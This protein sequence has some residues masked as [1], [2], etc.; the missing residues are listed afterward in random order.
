MRETVY[1]VAFQAQ[2]G[3][4]NP[5]PVTLHADALTEQEM[6][7]MTK[8]FG[9]ESAFLMEPTR[10]DCQVKARYFVPLHEME[11]CIHATVASTVVLV[12]RGMFSVSP[13]VFE[14]SCGAVRADWRREKDGSISVGVFQFLPRFM[15]KNPSREEVCQV[16]GIT[17]DDLGEGVIQSVATSRWKLIVPLKNRTVLDGLTPNFEE[18][19][20]LCDRYGTTGLY[21]FCREDSTQGRLF[22]ARQFPKRAGYPEDPATGV[23]ASALGAYLTKEQIWPV[24][25]GWNCYTIRQGFAMGRPSVIRSDIQVA[26]GE[27]VATRVT[28]SAVLVKEP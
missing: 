27:I 10:P 3:G 23:A 1:T 21:P 8:L 4:G 18:L 6:Q 25:E 15:Q 12:E 11:M 20:A 2:P 16:L 24:E 5:C 14:T 7:R 28:G 19:W 22:Y 13:I 17:P 26:Q 9:V